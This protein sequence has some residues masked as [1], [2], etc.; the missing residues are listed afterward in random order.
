MRETHGDAELPT[1]VKPPPQDSQCESLLA[2]MAFC[3]GCSGI[4]GFS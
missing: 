3:G 2:C 4:V 1:G